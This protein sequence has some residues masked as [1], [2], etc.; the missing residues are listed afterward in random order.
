MGIFVG[1]PN[2]IDFARTEHDQ[3]DNNNYERKKL[4]CT[5]N[6]CRN[7][8]TNKKTIDREENKN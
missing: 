4:L 3:Q 7:G 5:N 2:K 1:H 6:K 8:E